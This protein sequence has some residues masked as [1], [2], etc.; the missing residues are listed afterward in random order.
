MS[1][2]PRWTPIPGDRC[3]LEENDAFGTRTLVTVRKVHRGG[4]AIVHDGIEDREVGVSRLVE[5]PPFDLQASLDQWV[6][7]SAERKAQ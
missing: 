2:Q 5:P 3:W 1:N 7:C 6:P 4:N